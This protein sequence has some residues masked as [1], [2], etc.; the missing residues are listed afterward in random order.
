MHRTFEQ[1]RYSFFFNE[2]SI[3]RDLHA[4]IYTLKPFLSTI[5]RLA[6]TDFYGH[7]IS[8]ITSIYSRF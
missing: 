4:A 6:L 1:L 8:K 3:K 2:T 5:E 7:P